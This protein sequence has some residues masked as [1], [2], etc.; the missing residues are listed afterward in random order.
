MTSFYLLDLTLPSPLANLALDE[1]LLE[2]LEEQGGN[3]VLRLWESDRYFVVLGR[4]SRVDDDVHVEACR[5]DCVPILR[6]ASGGGTVLQGPGC[7]SYALVLPISFHTDLRDIRRTNEFVLRP[8]AGALSRWEPAIALRG[9]SDLAVERRKISGNAQR[10]TRTALLFHGTL[11]HGMQADIISRYV[12]QPKRQPEYREDRSHGEFLRTIDVRP[13]EIKEAIAAAWKADTE[14][15]SWPRLRMM[16]AMA[17]VAGRSMALQ[18]EG[19]QEN[20]C[21]GRRR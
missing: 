3:P 12:K 13:A 19:I 5:Q 15:K 4:S 18:A 11:L 17:Q 1:A 9:I 10:R 7:L 14:L 21:Q 8:I 2:E 16:K 20:C 6:R